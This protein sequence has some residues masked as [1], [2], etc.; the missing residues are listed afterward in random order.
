ML[1]VHSANTI[2]FNDHTVTGQD[3]QTSTLSHGPVGRIT[4]IQRPNG[5]HIA[6][7]G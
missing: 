5:S 3:N 2:E 7:P 4:G 6:S 1:F